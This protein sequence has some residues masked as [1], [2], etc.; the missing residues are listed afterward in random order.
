MV[1]KIFLFF[2]SLFLAIKLRVR[3]GGIALDESPLPKEKDVRKF[4]SCL[5]IRFFAP[6]N[7]QWEI[8]FR[9]TARKRQF[10]FLKWFNTEF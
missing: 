7:P 6:I 8:L 2:S 3:S 10:G 5:T 9:Y 4:A 1:G